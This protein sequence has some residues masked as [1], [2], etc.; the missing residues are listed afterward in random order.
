MYDLSRKAM[1]FARI[2]WGKMVGRVGGRLSPSKFLD[3]NILH[4]NSGRL[5][6]L[7]L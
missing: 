1:Q 6:G 2:I 7:D 5:R 3:L 4:R